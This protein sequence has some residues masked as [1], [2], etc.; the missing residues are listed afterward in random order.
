MTTDVDIITNKKNNVLRLPIQAIQETNG[1]KFVWLATESWKKEK[2]Q[3]TTGL[4]GE[5]WVE[6]I[7]GLK[8]GEKV[9]LK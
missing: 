6:I 7:N 2:R 3:I 5:G 4:S 9:L 1:Q 8:E